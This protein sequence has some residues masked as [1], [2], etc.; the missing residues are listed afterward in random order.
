M[1]KII[2]ACALLAAMTA[3]AQMTKEEKA[4]MKEA[5]SV[6]KKAQSTYN[7]AVKNEQSGRKETNFEKM[8]PA[9]EM[10]KPAL[11]NQYTKDDAHTWQVAADIEYQYY[12]KYDVEA[13]AD[14][15][16][17]PLLLEAAYNT[18]NYCMTFDN[19][20]QQQAKKPEE[21]QAQHKRYQQ[22]GA[23]PLLVCLQ[24]AQG[25]SS[26]DNQEEVKQ[27]VKYATVAY[28]GLAKSHL[29]SDFENPSKADWISYSKAFLAQSLS[30][31]K[32]STDAE[33]EAAYAELVGTKFESTAYQA[34]AMRFKDKNHDKYVEYLKKGL[35]SLAPSE[36][37]YANI[38]IMLMQDQYHND[39]KACLETIQL[40]KQN[41]PDNDNTVRAYLM[42]GQI[43]FDQKDYKKAEQTFQEAVEKYPNE[44]E[45]I[46]MPAKCAWQNA[47]T[48]NKK[49]DTQHAID[50]F[51]QLE[52]KY[53]DS[54]EY[55][56]EALYILYNNSNQLEKAKPYKKY[57]SAK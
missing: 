39:K 3:N 35:A 17:K 12:L 49:E 20:Y 7:G 45:A 26:S 34:L 52:Q 29:M 38:A 23:N 47:L 42:E 24:A 28:N 55:W 10:I 9:R 53:P 5:Q 19:L 6:V 33:V 13:K 48:T 21:A 2:L 16:R 30:N 15:S 41:L 57:Y 4:A 27:G 32:T 22:M 8:D 14:E 37:V 51:A 36:P 25:L 43:Y 1:K 46:T 44:T 50:M 18:A 56:G 31:L 11:T 40:I 54:P